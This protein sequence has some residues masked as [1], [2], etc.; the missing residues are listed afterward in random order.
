MVAALQ[1]MYKL[2]LILKYLRRK[3]APM[4]AALAVM[5]CTMMVIIV[6]SVMGGFLEM[7]RTAAQRLTGDITVLADYRG[8]P[9][10]EQL[11]G[12]L[13]ALP[14]VAAATPVMRSPGMAKFEDPV[15]GGD[16]V[17]LVEVVGIRPVEMDPIIGYESTLHWTL[18]HVRDRFGDAG[19]I[20]PR[21]HGMS[22]RPHPVWGFDD[23]VMGIVPGIEISPM[24]MRDSDGQ[25]WLSNSSL[26]LEATVTVAPVTQRGSVIE[27]R[28]GRFVVVNEFKSGLYDIDA[29]RVYVPFESLQ[30]LLAM[31]E[32]Q[33]ADPE[34]G[35]PTGVAIPARA[36][37]IMVKGRPGTP[38]DELERAV[39]QTTQA[40]RERHGDLPYLGT[41][42]WM[43]RHS[44]LLNAVQ[45]EKGLITFLFAIIGLVSIVMVAT[46]FY[47]IVLE[48]TRDIGILR[49]L[50]ASRS[51]IAGIFL[52]YGLAVG[53]VGSLLG[54]A[55]GVAIVTHLNEIQDVLYLFTRWI[56]QSV[57]DNGLDGWRMWNP[58]IY[59][60]DRIPSEVDRTEVGWIVVLA[61]ASSVAGALIPALLASRLDPVEALRYE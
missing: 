17:H 60:F 18:D 61:I 5:L 10:Y 26:G 13:R 37:E 48:K 29:Q 33:S 46:T 54:L 40:F 20:D 23:D 27:P 45:N 1:K 11:L 44:T 31:D 34:T 12:E 21:E 8:F 19:V 51:G 38:L 35:E 25:Y 56:N 55:A 42:T 39:R 36:T 53:T 14:E 7:M 58:Q 50:G 24:N 30:K 47:M 52:G 3:L 16:R 2:L 59:Y 6:V 49:A 57:L 9:H 28:T 15:F 43:Q 4:F 32:A 22:M 41:Q